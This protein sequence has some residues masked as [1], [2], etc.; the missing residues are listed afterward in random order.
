M[1]LLAREPGDEAEGDV[2]R[3]HGVLRVAH[4]GEG[5]GALSR[6]PRGRRW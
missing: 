3:A 5:R 2:A 1:G 6:S 4:D